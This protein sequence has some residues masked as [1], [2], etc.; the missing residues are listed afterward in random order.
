M[1]IWPERGAIYFR[2]SMGASAAL[3]PIA[4]AAL[5]VI[6]GATW[7]EA[8]IKS[9]IA[10]VTTATA[11]RILAWSGNHLS[12]RRPTIP[13]LWLFTYVAMIVVPGV[14]IAVDS[15]HV[16]RNT[17]Y[18][19]MISALVTVPIGALVAAVFYRFDRT[20]CRLFFDRPLTPLRRPSLAAA[21]VTV[22]SIVAVALSLNYVR[23]AGPLPIIALIQQPGEY[24]LLRELR[25]DS[26]KLLDS[27]LRYA[28]YVL[29]TFIWP[30]L[31]ALSLTM[32]LH[33]RSR[34]WWLAF[35]SA[36]FA[37]LLF[38]SLSTAKQ[39]VAALLVVLFLVVM[40]MRGATVRTATLLLMPVVVLAFP[41][42]VVL[43]LQVG[44]GNDLW[45]AITAILN[46]LFFIP[47]YVLYYYYEV[48]PTQVTHLHGSTIALLARLSG[49]D[50]F[51][52]ANYVYRYMYPERMESGLANA[53]FIGNAWADFGAIGVI[54]AG[55]LL[56]FVMQTVQ[57]IVFRSRKTAYD[58]SIYA[59]LLFGF[60]LVNSTAFPTVLLSNG[61]LAAV[62]LRD[63]LNRLDGGRTA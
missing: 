3:R 48:F 19:A 27:P 17:F 40:I 59:F 53:A 42:G 12:V 47:S 36:A 45:Y 60:W 38:V 46:R 2:G 7:G 10:L 41:V 30:F 4:L 25:E 35:A 33:T 54:M 26:F 50:N 16:A 1:K 56:G 6:L 58:V 22:A 24:L 51:D 5:A 62:V 52:S 37:G 13:A 44:S 11:I 31:V 21:F 29:R 15:T 23:E 14:V 20:E 61:V 63:V 34:N 28:Y 57:I 43:L 8:G 39:P 9:A 55:V 49:T 32:A 18:W